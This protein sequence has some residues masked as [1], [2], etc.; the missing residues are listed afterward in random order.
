MRA[1][2]EDRLLSWLRRRLGRDGLP[3]DDAA[4]LPPGWEG[5]RSTVVTVDSQIEGV[6]FPA[7]LDPAILA[8]RVLAVNLSDLAAMGARPAYALLALATPP[9][10]D[11]R[12][13]F[14]ALV[15]A[16][17]RH[18]VT[19]AGGDLARCPAGV[20]AT[21]TLLGAP[22]P[23]GRLL[24]RGGARPGHGLWV[25]GTLGESAAGA[26][27]VARGARLEGRRVV[28]PEDLGGGRPVPRA[29][30]R[31]ARRAA[32]R[33]VRR[34]L[35]PKPQIELG[36]RL[37]ELSEGAAMDLS[38]GLALD[39]RRLCRESGVGAEVEG[40]A[41]PT[42]PGFDALCR[43][44]GEDP[45]ELALGGGEDYVLLFTLPPETAPPGGHPC[46]RI[47][48][49]TRSRALSWRRKSRNGGRGEPLPELGWDHL[50]T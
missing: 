6:H 42:A 20:A 14:T 45:A 40:D 34:H 27:L 46:R 9:R 39:L 12:R 44:L 33:A 22:F 38:D 18:G 10:F 7:G 5:D 3:G 37:G 26:R 31:A 25:G 23:G 28:L 36:R 1:T 15:A 43:L 19:L 32:R 13:F 50:D 11:H 21:L 4:V 48:T 2:G 41:L 35:S 17:R 29:M 47:G 24:A 30:Q 16:C 8:R 49:V